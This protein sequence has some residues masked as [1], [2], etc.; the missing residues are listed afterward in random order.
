M[1]KI[2]IT[3]KRNGETYLIKEYEVSKERMEKIRQFFN[4][5][6]DKKRERHKKLFEEI[7]NKNSTTILGITAMLYKIFEEME[8]V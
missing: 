2:T 6:N 7:K 8:S 3:S 4:D 5:L 1:P